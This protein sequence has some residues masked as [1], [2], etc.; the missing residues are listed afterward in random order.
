MIKALYTSATGMKAQQLTVDVIANNLA[1]VNTAGFKR[2]QVDFQ[3]LLYV[4][5][6]R[7]GLDAAQGFQAPSGL[8]VGSGA[9]AVA[10]SKVFTPGVLDVTNRSLD[11]AILG[12]GFFQ[13]QLPDGSFAYTR[14]GSFQLDNNLNLVTSD[15]KRLQPLITLPQDTVDVRIGRDGSVNVTTSGS[16]DTQTNVGQITLAKFV[17]P[18][19]LSSEGASLL[20]ESP[21]SGPVQL[22]TPGTQGAGEL[23]QGALEK[24]NVDVVTELVGLITAQRAYEINSRAIRTADEMLGALNTLSR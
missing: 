23:E 16:P 4:N 7:P 14:N 10:T 1:N 6:Q 17:N 11:L 3:D 20:R 12:D 8:Q 9:R 13:V 22:V 19:G 5:V 2:S 21:A 15:G 18:A 24:S